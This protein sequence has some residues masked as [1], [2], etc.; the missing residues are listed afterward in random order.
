MDTSLVM[1]SF[2]DRCKKTG[3]LPV[4]KRTRGRSYLP[5]AFDGRAEGRAVW[6]G[7]CVGGKRFGGYPF[8]A[9]GKGKAKVMARLKQMTQIDPMFPASFLFL[10]RDVT[11]IADRD[12]WPQ[13]EM[14]T[15]ES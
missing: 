11:V 10:H 7:K 1:E 6:P 2:S 14:M 4:G 12:A 15:A 8:T 9:S 5:P 3:V 13:G